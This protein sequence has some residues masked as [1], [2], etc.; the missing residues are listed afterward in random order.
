MDRLQL[1]LHIIFAYRAKNAKIKEFLLKQISPTLAEDFLFAILV[2]LKILWRQGTR[3]NR[4][5][6]KAVLEA[7]YPALGVRMINS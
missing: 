3:R 7:L 2:L 1:I 4:K 6:Y 5:N